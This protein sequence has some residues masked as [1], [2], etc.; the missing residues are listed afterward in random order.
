MADP[1]MLL[2]VA[3]YAVQML[4]IT[5]LAELLFRMLP[6][7]AAGFRYAFW[8]LVLVAALVLPW[9]LRASPPVAAPAASVPAGVPA[10][11]LSQ[12]ADA[13]VAVTA[14]ASEW[15]SLLPWIFA[16]GV[17]LRLSWL[18]AGLVRLR[19]LRRSGAIV[20]DG[21][22]DE[23][24][25]RLG[26]RAELRVVPRLSQPVTFGV[27]RPV[28]LLPAALIDAEESIRRAAVTHELIH[29]VRHDWLSVL[30]EELLRAL[31]WWHPAVW[32]LTARVRLT[33]EE[34]T[35]HLAVL[36]TGNR[37]SYMAALLAFAD[38]S[39]V[40]PAPAFVRRAHLFQRIVLLSKESVMTSRRIV[41]SGVALALLLG[42][43]S[44]YAS[45]AFPILSAAAR[46]AADAGQAGALVR[47]DQP[48][49]A[50][51]P[52]PRR[53]SATPIGYPLEL[54]GTGFESALSVRVVVN[55]NG[56]VES[57]QAGARS[58]SAPRRASP[59]ATDRGEAA[60]LIALAEQ[61]AM[62]RFAAAAEE[63]IR[64][65]HYEPPAAAPIAFYIGVLFKP[66]ETTSVAERATPFAVSAG[67]EGAR[68][69]VGFIDTVTAVAQPAGRG[70][71]ASAVPQGRGGR[72]SG[73]AGAVGGS[74]DGP[75][76]VPPPP[77]P[78]PPPPAAGRVLVGPLSA[79]PGV[80]RNR[81]LEP[82][83]AV[84]SG[85]AV[86]IGGGI[87][88]PTQTRR[89]APVYP[90]IA[91]SARVQGVVILEL[92]LDEQGRVVD[93]RVL[94]SI[95]LLDQAALDAVRQWEYTPTLLNGVP[96]PVI[97][98]VTVEFKL[99][100]PAPRN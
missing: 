67:P 48:A 12:T 49:T 77:P 51:N 53:L 13:A 81:V 92:R 34:F 75:R 5:A 55:A 93:A 24:L 63:A 18:T 57:A 50:E 46:P 17:V 82:G 42:A 86:R 73:A 71:G 21:L 38:S 88:P 20:R 29:V 66:G 100:E 60:R 31:F 62:G 91:Q 45:E 98:T 54:A 9:L 36:A 83:A 30:G 16:A 32:W 61:E 89:V 28:V 84:P 74:V 95:P 22:Y 94:R 68:L 99:E 44:W 26:A 40:E 97:M 76:A 43:G 23:L 1:Q 64:Q 27:R 37:R 2:N 10:L 14:S 8:R 3:P 69:M 7:A 72:Q 52:V 25:E 65:W 90:P 35:D 56:F 4:C 47:D 58:V 87:R 15:F 70:R 96:T 59:A 41:A 33:R 39:P 80:Q 79:E 19:V 85:S 78:P 11:P 6:V